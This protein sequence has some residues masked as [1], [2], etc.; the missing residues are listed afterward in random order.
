[1][2][3]TNS[4]HFLSLIKYEALE[5]TGLYGSEHEV[6]TPSF[7]LRAVIVSSSMT[8]VDKGSQQ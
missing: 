6:N 4:F 7:I 3:S 5:H 8:D 2:L 1:M